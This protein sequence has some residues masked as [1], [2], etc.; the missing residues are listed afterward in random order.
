MQLPAS[1]CRPPKPQLCHHTCPMTVL[2]V[3]CFLL[4]VTGIIL[5]AM[6]QLSSIS[7]WNFPL[8]DSQNITENNISVT[9]INSDLK[10]ENQML[11]NRSVELEE[12]YGLLNKTLVKFISLD[13][14]T[15]GE[16]AKLM[17]K[18]DNLT[19]TNAHLT[20]EYRKAVQRSVEQEETLVNMSRTIA[21]LSTS[22]SEL[23]LGK[24]KLEETNKL[25]QVLQEEEIKAREKIQGI[26]GE[27]REQNHH[28]TSLLEK[29]RADVDQYKEEQKKIEAK[30]QSVEEAYHFLDRYCPVVNQNTQER[31]CKKCADGWSLFQSKCYYFSSRSLS[32]SSSRV[33]CQTH[34]ADLIIINTEEEQNFTHETSHKTDQTNTRLWL[35]M[36]DIQHEGDWRWVDGQQVTSSPQYWLARPGVGTEPDDWRSED[37]E[38]EDCGHMDTSEDVLQAWMDG[39]CKI[40]YR[41]ICEMNI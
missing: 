22:N 19:W 16:R 1:E 25:K 27:T 40:A 9:A 5:L 7:K 18:I 2:S 39:S 15:T 10:I 21:D 20:D 32:W 6:Y 4:I 13:L 31:V 17:E 23:Q 14:A 24:Q 30:L 11:M 36:S 28:L 34:S 12:Q 37:P 3:L 41:W 33:W 38:G 8:F 35:G 26:L 29:Q